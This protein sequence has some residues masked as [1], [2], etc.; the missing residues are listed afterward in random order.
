MV[1]TKLSS[2]P[3][4]SAM[5]G[6][7][8]ALQVRMQTRPHLLLL[9]IHLSATEGEVTHMDR[10]LEGSIDIGNRDQH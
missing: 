9:H 7:A 8:V 10:P 2:R 3:E 1:T 6:P 4:R 5:E